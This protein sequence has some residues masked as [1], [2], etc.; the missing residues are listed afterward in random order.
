MSS[1]TSTV[2]I[3]TSAAVTTYDVAVKLKKKSLLKKLV[4]EK[5]VVFSAKVQT[6]GVDTTYKEKKIN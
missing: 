1:L 4:V 3:I 2:T 6:H 5:V